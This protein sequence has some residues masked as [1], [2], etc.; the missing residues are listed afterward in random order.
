MRTI[1]LAPILALSLA[2]AALPAFADG[3]ASASM[4]RKPSG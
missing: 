1:I 3:P 2:A 4:S